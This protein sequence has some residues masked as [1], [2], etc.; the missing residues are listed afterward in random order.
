[1][2]K[3]VLSGLLVAAAVAGGQAHAAPLVSVGDVTVAPSVRT[4]DVDVF[5]DV[6]EYVNIGVL[7]GRASSVVTDG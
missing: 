5:E 6:L 1:M 2:R 7:W 3:A 4:G